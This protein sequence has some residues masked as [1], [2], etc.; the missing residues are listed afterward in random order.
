M[1]HKKYLED[2]KEIKQLMHKSSKFISL[3]G[4]SGIMAGVYALG[5][6][7][8]AYKLLENKTVYIR[9]YST[10]N[11]LLVKQL[12]FIALGVAVLA[13]CTAY[14]LSKNKAKKNGEKL[15]EA[16]TKYLLVDLAIPLIT[17]GIFGLILLYHEHFGVI[18]PITLIFYG[19]A[20]VSASKY[21]LN[22]IKY[23]GIS[24]IV[25]G[26]LSAFYVGY[27]LYFWAFGFG[28]LHIIYGV[29]MYIKEK[30]T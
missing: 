19:L 10:N 8:W 23:L 25:V 22:T 29:A 9:D 13:I 28:V 14:I 1:E 17:G 18:A 27:G 16:T 12:L 11:V 30:Q 20:L 21:T 2:L 24:E 15:W 26:L 5:G 6:S 3:S 4:L 7:Y